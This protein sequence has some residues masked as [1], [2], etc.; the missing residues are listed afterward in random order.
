M[1]SR[2]DFNKKELVRFIY[3]FDLD[4]NLNMLALDIYKAKLILKEEGC[5]ELLERLERDD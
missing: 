5:E 3:Q 1:N 2:Y 4:D